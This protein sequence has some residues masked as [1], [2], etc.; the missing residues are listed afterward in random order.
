[1]YLECI[2]SVF[3]L[4]GNVFWYSKGIFPFWVLFGNKNVFFPF[5]NVFGMYSKC[6][7]PLLEMYF[8]IQK[9]F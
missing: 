3:F 5:E 9:V 7:S 4:F 8:G 6:I 1:M 2:Q